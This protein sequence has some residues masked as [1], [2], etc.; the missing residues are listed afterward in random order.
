MAV[1]VLGYDFFKK[2]LTAEA[3]L[4][5]KTVKAFII[6]DASPAEARKTFDRYVGYLKAARVEPKITGGDSAAVLVARD[7]LY[8][9]LVLRLSGPY[10]VGASNVEEPEKGMDLLDA[11]EKAGRGAR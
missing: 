11:L 8:K 3:V 5:G 4:G 7:P 10:L 6:F 2:G 1:S 9:G